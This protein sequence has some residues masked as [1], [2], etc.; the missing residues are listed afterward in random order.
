MTTLTTAPRTVTTDRRP[1]WAAMARAE[2]GDELKGILREPAAL[3]F[4]VLMPVLFFA[5]FVGVFGREDAD[6]LPVGTTML[7]TF[8]TYAVVAIATMTPGIGLA[9][10][11]ERGWLRAV[12]VSPVPV[13]IVLAAK[14][15]AIL[16]YALGILLAMTGTAAALGVLDLGLGTW[17]ALAGT[18]LLGALPFA[19]VGLTVGAFA[20]TNATT[21]ILNAVVIPMAV[22][23]GLWMPLEVLPDVAADVAPLLPTYHLSQIGLALVHGGGSVIDHLAALLVTT[24]VAAAGAIWAYRRSTT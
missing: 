18:L 6:G 15:V 17:F 13:P 4:A 14:V 20:A 16:P 3:F 23:S 9:E 19:L 2:V 24:A 21:A 8:G 22:A 1:P 12:R 5:L 10:A 11:R 7:A